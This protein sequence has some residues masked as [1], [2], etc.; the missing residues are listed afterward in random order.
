M[1]IW[2]IIESQWDVLKGSPVPHNLVVDPT[3][4]DL[5]IYNP[6]IYDRFIG[7][8]VLLSHGGKAR[9]QEK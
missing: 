7:G 1:I 8:W 5:T 4:V 9:K 6:V 2:A 3:N